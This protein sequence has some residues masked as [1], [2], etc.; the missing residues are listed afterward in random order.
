MTSIQDLLM[1]VLT[2]AVAWVAVFLCWALFEAAKLLR[3]ANSVVTDA[4]EKISRLERAAL[5]IKDKLESSVNYLGLLAEGGRALL[6]MFTKRHGGSSSDEEEE[7]PKGKKK[8][9]SALFDE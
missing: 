7:M 9:K 8:K 2:I 4:R 3:Q 1:L 6:T 5:M